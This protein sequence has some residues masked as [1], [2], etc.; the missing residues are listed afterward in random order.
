[1]RRFLLAMSVTAAGLLLGGA[2]AG[3]PSR[4]KSDVV[5]EDVQSTPPVVDTTEL[6]QVPVLSTTLPSIDTDSTAAA[7]GPA[8]AVTLPFPA[9]TSPADTSLTAESTN[10]D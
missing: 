8:V 4:V 2:I 6:P 10:P 9:G 5:I 1:M 3:W 7:G